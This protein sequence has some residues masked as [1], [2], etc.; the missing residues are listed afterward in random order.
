MQR[1]RL[2]QFESV[3]AQGIRFY[4]F[5]K[6]FAKQRYQ[7]HNA[8]YARCIKF[9]LVDEEKKIEATI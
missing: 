4:K 8:K 5:H 9:S 1:K 2:G 3:V 7:F 6:K